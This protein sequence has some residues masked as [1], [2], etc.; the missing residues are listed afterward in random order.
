MDIKFLGN[1]NMN[2]KMWLTYSY[3]YEK[4][5]KTLF[6]G[7]GR[8]KDIVTFKHVLA[9]PAF[10]RNAI[11]NIRIHTMHKRKIDGYNKISDLVDE[12]SNGRPPP[13]NLVNTMN[14][15][16]P[17]KD[18]TTGIVYRNAAHACRELDIPA[19]R[20]SYHLRKMTGFKSIYGHKFEY[21]P[22]HKIT[23]PVVKPSDTSPVPELHSR[24]IYNHD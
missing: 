6:I 14:R 17:V 21:A 13:L 18:I 24:L 23:D 19:G 10:D 3:E 9:N 15:G 7:C 11:Y 16:T 20:M 5:E 12:L 1:L 2:T 22:N 4:D 8:M